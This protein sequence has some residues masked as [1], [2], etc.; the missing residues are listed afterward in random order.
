MKTYSSWTT[1]ESGMINPGKGLPLFPSEQFWSLQVMYC[2]PAGR[3][4][5]GAKKYRKVENKPSDSI[6]WT[7][8]AKP[9]FS[10]IDKAESC[11]SVLASAK[12]G[13]LPRD[14]ALTHG[15]LWKCPPPPISALWLRKEP[16]HS[17]ALENWISSIAWRVSTQ[18]AP[19]R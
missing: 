3:R 17:L 13:S 11:P 1:R 19:G 18:P 9:L 12:W 2:D 14:R 7:T 15:A 10:L 6:T 8:E 5:T 16:S 4:E